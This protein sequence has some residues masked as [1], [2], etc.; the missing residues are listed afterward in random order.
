M[1]AGGIY[2]FFYGDQPHAFPAIQ[3]YVGRIIRTSEQFQPLYSEPGSYARP[4]KKMH[5]PADKD[6]PQAVCGK[7]HVIRELSS[8]ASP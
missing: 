2:S 4:V 5:H 8:M 6:R 1:A 3:P 7:V